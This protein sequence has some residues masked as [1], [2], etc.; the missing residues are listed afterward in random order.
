LPDHV[1]V[2]L[3]APVAV[4]NGIDVVVNGAA[5][6]PLTNFV[7]IVVS[8]VGALVPGAVV[9]IDV[10]ELGGVVGFVTRLELVVFDVCA[11]V[12]GGGVGVD[13]VVVVAEATSRGG[14]VEELE[15]GSRLCASCRAVADGSFGVVPTRRAWPDECEIPEWSTGR[16]VAL[17][18]T[19]ATAMAV[20][21]TVAVT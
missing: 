20:P 21:S 2:V 9:A 11:E 4:V 1:V 17:A 8:S 18:T 15:I 12:V 14:D 7:F 13:V 16:S 10:G 3:T 6:F 19:M 5:S